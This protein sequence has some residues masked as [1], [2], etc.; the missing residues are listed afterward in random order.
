MKFADAKDIKRA[1]ELGLH[2]GATRSTRTEIARGK[3]S[4]M[5]AAIRDKRKILGRLEAIANEWTD[6][7][8]LLPFINQCL[9]LWPRSIYTQAYDAGKRQGQYIRGMRQSW[10]SSEYLDISKEA[11]YRKGKITLESGKTITG[12]EYDE[13]DPVA[14]IIFNT[15]F[16]FNAN[17]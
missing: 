11:L 15:I 17:L 5:A 8:I 1:Q 7:S 16:K 9:L 4:A 12:Y 2:S 6:N 14:I 13:W 10:N 3:S